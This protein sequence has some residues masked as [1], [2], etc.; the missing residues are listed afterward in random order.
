MSKDERSKLNA[1][2]TKAYRRA[3][4]I[5]YTER[6]SN[7]EVF[8]RTGCETMPETQVRRCKLRYFGHVVG[9]D[10]LEQDIMLGMVPGLKMQ[11]GQKKQ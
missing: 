1:S 2:E 11:G 10:S 9:H 4:G 7:Q 6:V 8:A 5:R 3:L